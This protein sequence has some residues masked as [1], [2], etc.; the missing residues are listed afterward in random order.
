MVDAER[1]RAGSS[2]VAGPTPE[3]PRLA[4]A[5]ARR[6]GRD[7]CDAMDTI[8]VAG[9]DGE[10]L[11]AAV[12]TAGH[13]LVDATHAGAAE[14]A[15]RAAWPRLADSPLARMLARVDPG[16]EREAEIAQALAEASTGSDALG[17]ALDRWLRSLPTLLGFTSLADALEAQ[18]AVAI[19]ARPN[20][21]VLAVV[22]D[23]GARWV[24]ALAATG[25][26]LT[27]L[28]PSHAVA[29]QTRSVAYE[30]GMSKRV[31]W[32]IEPVAQLRRHGVE[33]I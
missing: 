9:L 29:T 30:V 23:F 8:E 13:A 6:A 5:N 21:Q 28:H 12:A 18:L 7:F 25:A 27:L 24:R 22:P 33:R 26:H 20:A 4:L 3:V 10:A 16:I 31:R 32:V 1:P 19:A 15:V 2:A 14:L 11:A 17:A